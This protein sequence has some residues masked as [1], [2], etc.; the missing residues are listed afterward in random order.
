VFKGWIIISGVCLLAAVAFLL[1]GH[2]DGAFVFGVLGI[3][4]WFLN[5][6]VRLKRRSEESPAEAANAERG[7]GR[8]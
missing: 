8:G 7:N 2:I 1:R 4:A 5:V 3:V 6:R